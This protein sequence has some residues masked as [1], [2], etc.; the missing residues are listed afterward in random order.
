MRNLFLLAILLISTNAA[1]AA[2]P[3]IKKEMLALGFEEKV[4]LKAASIYQHTKS[5]RCYSLIDWSHGSA[6]SL[7]E[8]SDF[9]IESTEEINKRRAIEEAAAKEKRKLELLRELESLK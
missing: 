6:P 3:P 5:G 8:C 9:G 4:V 1:Y 7:V 2:I